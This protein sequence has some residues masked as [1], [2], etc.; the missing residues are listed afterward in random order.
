M[1]FPCGLR[2]DCEFP[3]SA[4]A[5][6]SDKHLQHCFCKL[7]LTQCVTW[8]FILE[9]DYVIGTNRASSEEPSFPFSS[10]FYAACWGKVEV[11]KAWLWFAISGKCRHLEFDLLFIGLS[12]L[13]AISEFLFPFSNRPSWEVDLVSL[14]NAQDRYAYFSDMLTSLGSYLLFDLL[15][16]HIYHNFKKDFKNMLKAFWLFSKEGIIQIA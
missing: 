1:S 11:G 7:D 8:G 9:Y 14:M 12:R 13:V 3:H 15:S 6:P 16:C 2:T 4:F 10:A 5:F